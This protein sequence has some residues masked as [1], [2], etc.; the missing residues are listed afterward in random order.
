MRSLRLQ[1]AMCAAVVAALRVLA[2]DVGPVR[3]A[4]MDVLAGAG[5][6]PGTAA[7][8]IASAVVA[9]FDPL[10]YVVLVGVVLCA[11]LARGR[12][13]A[14]LV[15]VGVMVGAA[16]TTQALKQLLAAPR[17]PPGFPYLPPDAFPSGHT[18]AAGALGFGVVLIT[19]P[20]RRR[21]V[22]FAAAATTVAVAVAL[23]A[24]G[25]H[26]PSDVLGALCVAAAWGAIGLR[27]VEIRHRARPAGR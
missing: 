25:L 16:A 11:A 5:L 26:F 4:D 21:P 20:A 1:L 15:A 6:R 3:R 24:L 19:P 27:V 10:P 8:R 9:P 23:V 13:R 2:F 17:V 22:A 14:G 12:G 7:E 18:T